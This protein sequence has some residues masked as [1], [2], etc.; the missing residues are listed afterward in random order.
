MGAEFNEAVSVLKYLPV[1][2]VFSSHLLLVKKGTL[3]FSF[4]S[5]NFR[6]LLRN[7]SLDTMFILRRNRLQAHIL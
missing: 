3:L 1:L 5:L 7:F 2:G 4:H 6:E